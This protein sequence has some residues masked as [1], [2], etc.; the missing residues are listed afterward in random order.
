MTKNIKKRFDEFIESS[1]FLGKGSKGPLCVGL[2]VTRYAL[3]NGVPLNPDSLLT[4]K[5]GQVSTLGKSQVQSILA[6]HGITQVLAEEGGR[7]SR[8]SIGNMQV[9]VAFLN[10]LDPS[11]EELKMI[12]SFWVELVKAFFSSKP[13]KLHLDPSKSMSMVVRDL[14]QQ[15]KRRQKESQGTMIVG[16]ILQ[17]L[18][19]AKLDILTDGA[20]EHHGANVADEQSGR[21]GDFLLGDVSIHVTTFPGEAVMRKCRQNLEAGLRPLL[22]TI[23]RGVQ[24]AEG[25]SEQFEIAERVDIYDAERFL[26]GNF[27]ELGKFAEAEREPVIRRIIEKY[28]ALIR[29]YETDQSLRI[30]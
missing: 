3:K 20:V 30:E 5:G 19:G 25:L 6:D 14:L 29:L 15:A 28:N 24:I 4:E 27:Y 23:G 9:F 7:T 11:P 12:E 10:E 21:T 13:L 1:K 18:V 2:T 22:M 8:G 26:S 17:H 16:T